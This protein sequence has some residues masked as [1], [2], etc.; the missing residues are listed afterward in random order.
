MSR[1]LIEA[2]AEAASRVHVF[3][4]FNDWTSDR[5]RGLPVEIC[6]Y[7]EDDEQEIIVIERHPAE[8]EQSV[9]LAKVV[10]RLRAIAVLRSLREHGPSEEMIEAASIQAQKPAGWHAVYPNIWNAM[11]DSLLHSTKGPDH[12]E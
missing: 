10:N 12:A 9:V 8:V 3:S 7:G 11:L 6:R 5:V 4:R 2:M 1:E